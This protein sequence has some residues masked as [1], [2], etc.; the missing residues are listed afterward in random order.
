LE[1]PTTDGVVL[2]PSAFGITTGSPPSRTTTTEFVV[3]K[4]I[5]TA[6]GIG[7]CLLFFLV[8]GLK[9]RWG[10][11][12]LATARAALREVSPRLGLALVVGF[13]A[14]LGLPGL[15]GFWGEF[16]A[17]YAAWSPAPDRPPTMRN[18]CR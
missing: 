6:R 15:V 11:A 4:S 12:D 8:G 17:M 10:S 18:A 3:P 2:A 14:S 1:N 13:A 9:D 5:P 7:P 16:L